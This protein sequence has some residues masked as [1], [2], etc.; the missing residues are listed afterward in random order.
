MTTCILRAMLAVLLGGLVGPIFATAALADATRDDQWHLD[1]LDVAG[2]HQITRGEGVVVAVIDSGVDATHP[3]LEGSVLPGIDLVENG[4]SRTWNPAA[5][6]TAM[7]GLIA[8][9]GH[10]LDNTDGA[11]GLAPEAKI[12]PVR[13]S[14]VGAAGVGTPDLIPQGMSWAISNGADVVSV[15]LADAVGEPYIDAVAA[16]QEA[17][18]VVIAGAGNRPDATEVAFPAALPGVVAAAAVGRD[19]SHAEISVTGPE[20]TLAAPGVETLTTGL[21]HGYYESGGTS[22]ATAIIAGAA[23]LVRAQFPE[24]SADEVV[25]RLIYTADDAGPP[26]HDTRYGH[27]IVNIVAALTEDV[28]PLEPTP[29]GDGTE[30]PPDRPGKEPDRGR[31]AALIAGGVLV[32]LA[33]LAVTLAVARRPR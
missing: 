32:L 29:T 22:A 27:G 25:H 12:L 19:G 20:I 23:A 16:A 21:E 2:G 5:H 30:S 10:G 6:G 24:L 18:I 26:G 3:D 1:F 11:L 17:D 4:D 13:V 8:G 7:A 15:S 31:N 33:I 9:H 28:P 14:R